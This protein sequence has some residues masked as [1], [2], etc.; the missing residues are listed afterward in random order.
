MAWL[1]RHSVKLALSVAVAAAFGWLLHAGAF[2]LIPSGEAL[3][4]VQWSHFGAYLLLFSGVHWLRAVRWRWLLAPLYPVALSKLLTASFIGFAAIVLLPMRAGELV[5]PVLIRKKGHISGWAAAGTIAAERIVDGLL[6]SCLLA[7]GL[8]L[9]TPLD[10]LPDHIGQL[11]ISARVVPAAAYAALLLFAV[12]F[13]AMALFYFHKAW[14]ERT[15][16]RIIGLISPRLAAWFA[17]K[18]EKLVE[19]LSFLPRRRLSLGFLGETLAYWLL[20]ATATWVLARGSG[21]TSFSF[22]EA[23]VLMGVLG[24]GILV[25]NAPGFFGQFQFSIYAGFAIY[26][27]EHVIHGAGAAFVFLTYVGQMAITGI[28]A[29]AAALVEHLGLPEILDSDAEALETPESDAPH[30][31]PAEAHLARGL[32]RVSSNRTSGT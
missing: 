10:P 22:A 20:N 2:S 23:L 31:A 27:P 6:L 17:A 30:P 1:R 19:G 11:P 5:R 12:A 26:Y 9:S 8:L 28:A 4:R 14:A 15:T 21:F 18:V 16:R 24:L 25:P 29:A 7:L 32:T 3:K 13:A